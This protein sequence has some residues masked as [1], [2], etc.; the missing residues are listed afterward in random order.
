MYQLQVCTT[1]HRW[2]CTCTVASVFNYV[3]N[4]DD[5]DDDDDDVSHGFII[6]HTTEI[7]W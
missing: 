1:V 3:F 6:K 2:T 5:D 4:D 7:R